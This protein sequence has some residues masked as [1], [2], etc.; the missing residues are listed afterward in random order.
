MLDRTLQEAV[1]I[2]R[3]GVELRVTDVARNML[4]DQERYAL[5]DRVRPQTKLAF[6]S[7]TVG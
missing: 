5:L 7:R 2:I 6:V 3:H 1:R 4:F